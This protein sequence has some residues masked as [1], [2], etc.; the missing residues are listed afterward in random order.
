[1]R[2]NS[3]EEKKSNKRFLEPKQIRIGDVLE[4]ATAS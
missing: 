4:D 2:P 3:R 1:M